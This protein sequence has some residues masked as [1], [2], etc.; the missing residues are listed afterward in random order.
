MVKTLK[1]VLTV[2]FILNLKTITSVGTVGVKMIRSTSIEAYNTIR[3][4]GV[5]TERLRDAYHFIFQHGP[6]TGQE[7]NNI[8]P[9]NGAWKLLSPLRRV[10]IVS[11]VGKKKCSITGY[12]ALLWD[13]NGKLP[14]EAVKVKTKNQII[15][16][17]K[18][19]LER[20]LSGSTCNTC[21][22]N[23]LLCGHNRRN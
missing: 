4:N 14:I 6:L 9:G 22:C 21:G 19:E 16:E 5:L 10:G 7:L 12:N 15:K 2:S 1:S 20:A 13:V 18:L 8:M 17:L 23:E 11:E 3:N